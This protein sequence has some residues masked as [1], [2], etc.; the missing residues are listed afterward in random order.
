MIEFFHSLFSSDYMPH[1]ACYMWQQDLLLLHVGSDALIALSYF[2]IPFAIVYFVRKRKDLMYRN[3]AFLFSAFI[4]A[5]GITHLLGIWAVWEGIYHITGFF[6]LGTAL[7]SVATAIAIWPFLPKALAIP[8]PD[9]LKNSNEALQKELA[10]REILERKLRKHQDELEAIVYERTKE[11]EKA[12]REL[13]AA[14]DQLEQSA[15]GLKSSEE[16]FVLAA[17]ASNSGI[18]DWIDVDQEEGWW[19][20][21]FYELLGYDNLEI[22]ATQTQFSALLHPADKKRALEATEALK[23]GSSSFDVEYRLKTKFS[24]YKWFR[25]RG[26]IHRGTSRTPTRMVG[27]IADIDRQKLAEANLVSYA[28]QL[29]MARD[30]AES[31]TRAKSEFL[32]NMSHEIRTPMN[33]ILGFTDVLKESDLDESQQKHLDIIRDSGRRLISLIN[34]ILD[35]SKIEA[36]HVAFKKTV[37]SPEDLVRSVLEMF[38]VHAQ[39]KQNELHY[40]IDAGVPAT[41]LGDQQRIQQLLINLVAN[42]VKFTQHG[43]VEVSVFSAPLSNNRIAL[44][45]IV[46]DTGIGIPKDRLEDIFNNFTQVDASDTRTFGGSGLGLAISQRLAQLMG[47]AISVNSE[48]G[49][50]SIFEARVVVQGAP[51]QVKVKPQPT[52]RPPIVNREGPPLEILLAEDDPSSRQLAAYVVAQMGHQIEIATNGREAIQHLS[53]KRYDVILMD[54]QM[55]GIDGLQVTEHIRKTIKRESQPRIIAVTAR[56]MQGEKERFL[57]A[58]MDAYLSKPYTRDQLIAVLN[59]TI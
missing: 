58:G 56:T 27:S 49:E 42:A 12:N 19:S 46:Q 15:Q 34:N 33:S 47:G 52:D 37:F 50:G 10:E 36:G 21:R 4:L 59:R 5:C 48:L 35:L 22:P 18:W 16:R 1:G 41:L 45:M 17:K 3:I 38:V 20:P 28:K 40:E 53:Q 7:I 13:V 31:G 32:A 14:F 57:S 8:S 29:K 11:L 43:R 24:G 25:G 9:Q 6:K 55:P 2:S 30:K 51:R 23:A 39:E 26:V 44:S 54:I